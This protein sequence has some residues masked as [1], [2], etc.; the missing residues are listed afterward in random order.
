MC[1][2]FVRSGGLILCMPNFL[3][4]CQRCPVWVTSYVRIGRGGGASRSAATEQRRP[5]SRAATEDG[6]DSA[7]RRTAVSVSYQ[8][9]TVN[10]C[11][12]RRLVICEARAAHTCRRPDR[13]RSTYLRDVK[14]AHAE[15]PCFRDHRAKHRLHR[16]VGRPRRHL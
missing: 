5:E 14:A 16:G 1:I 4:A 11:R 8:L 7:V 9:S 12:S 2:D 15:W 13:R 10:L 3:I 6:A